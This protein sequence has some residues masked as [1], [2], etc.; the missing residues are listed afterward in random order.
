MWVRARQLLEEVEHVRPTFS[1]VPSWEPPLDV[2][3]TPTEVWVLV[4]LP[5]VAPEAVELVLEE[6]TLVIR[7]ARSVPPAFRRAVVHRMEIPT[8]RFERAVQL[9]SASCELRAR[10][11]FHGCLLVSLTKPR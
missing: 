11:V 3:E 9:P 5:G 7:G 4:A 1:D 6:S 8:G 2:F 10:D